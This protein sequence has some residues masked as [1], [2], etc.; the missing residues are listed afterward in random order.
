MDIAG[1]IIG[2]LDRLLDL[3]GMAQLRQGL[4]LGLLTLGAVGDGVIGLLRAALEKIFD[5]LIALVEMIMDKLAQVVGA[6][7]EIFEEVPKLFSGFLGFL[8]AVFP[9]FPPEIMLLLTFGIAAVVFV[10]IIKAIRR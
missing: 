3:P 1:L 5:G 4:R 8:S 9:F 10:G 7:L 2:G 6:V